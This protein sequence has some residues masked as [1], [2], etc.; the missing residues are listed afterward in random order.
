MQTHHFKLPVLIMLTG[1]NTDVSSLSNEMICNCFTLFPSDIGWRDP[2]RMYNSTGPVLFFK[3]VQTAVPLT[4]M[5]ITLYGCIFAAD[6][7]NLSK[8]PYDFASII[9]QTKTLAPASIKTFTT[10]LLMNKF[11]LKSC[12]FGILNNFIFQI[13]NWYV[14]FLLPLSSLFAASIL[15]SSITFVVFCWWQTLSKWPTL[16]QLK[17]F[18]FIALHSFTWFDLKG[19]PHL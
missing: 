2:G 9:R 17:H 12:F 18:E 4:F 10:Q 13:F 6:G 3:M 1:L 5:G 15:L 19:K 14:S 7:F 8:I 16:L 11:F